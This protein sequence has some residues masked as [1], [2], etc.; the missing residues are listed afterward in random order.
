MITTIVGC[1]EVGKLA[2]VMILPLS[3]S[4]FTIVTIVGC[5]EVRKITLLL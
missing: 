3:P 2:S 5:G 4:L 1:G